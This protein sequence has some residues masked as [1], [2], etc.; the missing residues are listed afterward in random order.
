LMA[1]KMGDNQ[2]TPENPSRCHQVNFT[3]Y[4][5]IDG[6]YSGY[7]FASG[8]EVQV[9]VVAPAGTEIPGLAQIASPGVRLNDLKGG[10]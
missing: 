1:M 10:N 3:E 4:R 2:S 5:K 8:T 9:P 7:P 6:K